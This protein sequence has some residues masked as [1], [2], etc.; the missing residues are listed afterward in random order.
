MWPDTFF[1]VKNAHICYILVLDHQVKQTF[2][3]SVK[4]TMTVPVLMF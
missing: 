1:K 2:V 4:L 3:K